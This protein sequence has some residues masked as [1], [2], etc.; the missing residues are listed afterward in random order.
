MTPEDQ[1]VAKEISENLG[2]RAE[3][4]IGTLTGDNTFGGYANH[5]LRKETEHL[6]RE[7]QKLGVNFFG[8]ITNE[9]DGMFQCYGS[10]AAI[11]SSLEV[12]FEG[13]RQTMSHAKSS[14]HPY[15]GYEY[16]GEVIALCETYWRMCIVAL[17]NTYKGQFALPLRLMQLSSENLKVV[18]VLFGDDLFRPVGLTICNTFI[19]E[20]MEGIALEFST[21]H[22]LSAYSEE[23]H[24]N[25]KEL[26]KKALAAMGREA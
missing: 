7:V 26:Q 14:F 1:K 3:V 16:A 21:V 18:K 20:H 13:L 23:I 22:E 5:S 10:R 12:L 15:I 11:L 2:G 4:K 8:V 17:E 6:V 25:L 19:S 24:R 9:E